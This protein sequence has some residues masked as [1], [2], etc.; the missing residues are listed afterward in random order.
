MAKAAFPGLISQKKLT[1]EKNLFIVQ[2]PLDQQAL[3]YDHVHSG[4]AEGLGQVQSSFISRSF[5]VGGYLRG[6]LLLPAPAPGLKLHSISMALVQTVSLLSRKRTPRHVETC[7]PETYEFMRLKGDELENEVVH[8]GA[9]CRARPSFPG[10][11]EIEIE[12]ITKLPTD[13]QARPTTI[14]GGDAH[15]R[16]NHQI[17]FAIVYDIDGANPERD[18]RGQVLRKRYRVTWPV[19]LTSCALRWRSLVLPEYSATDTNPVPS[20][21][22]NVWRGRTEHETQD[23]CNCGEGLEELVGYED[24]AEAQTNVFTTALMRQ[25]LISERSTGAAIGGASS[26]SRSRP[27]GTRRA[28]ANGSGRGTA[29]SSPSRSRTRQPRDRSTARGLQAGGGGSRSASLTPRTPRGRSRAVT[30]DRISIDFERDEEES[31]EW[32]QGDDI[33]E[34]ASSDGAQGGEAWDEEEDEELMDKL[35][36]ERQKREQLYTTQFEE[37]GLGSSSAATGSSRHQQNNRR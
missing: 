30:P 24:E 26:A 13:N 35:E 3:S 18:S 34:E 25:L 2:A 11:D 8:T 21:D 7:L 10:S 20:R 31:Q 9:L 28:D 29:T 12:W 33:D 14:L 23:H 19:N 22:R 1:A 37:M 5:T 17:E 6:A 27:R 36:R 32:L 4:F 16:L 15:I